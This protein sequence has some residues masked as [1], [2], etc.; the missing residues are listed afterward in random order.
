MLRVGF[1]V[2]VVLLLMSRRVLTAGNCHHC[3]YVQGV[4]SRYCTKRSGAHASWPGARPVN[5]ALIMRRKC[6]S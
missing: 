5:A 4:D 6:S 3:A 1:G 2:T